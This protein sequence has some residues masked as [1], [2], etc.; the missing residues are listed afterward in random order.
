M[1]RRFH[2][3][4]LLLLAIGLLG[5][6]LTLTMRYRVE[7]ASRRVALVLDYAQL[8]TLAAATGI[9]VGEALS[10]FRSAGITGVSVS[11]EPLAGLQD[12]GVVSVQAVPVPNGQEYRLTFSNPHIASRAA[13]HLSHLVRGAT[14]IP[15]KGDRVTVAGPGGGTIYLPGRFADLADTPTGIDPDTVQQI[16]QAGLMPIARVMNP[17]GLDV[18]SLRWAL[19]GLQEQ[20]ITTVIF[21]G[22]EVLGFSGLVKETAQAFRDYGLYYGSIEFGKQ[23]GDQTMSEQLK[24]RLLRVH[25]ISSGEMARLTPKEAVERYVRASSER[26]IRLNYVRLPDTVTAHTLQD[27]LDYVQHLARDTARSGFGLPRNSAPSTFTRVWPDNLIGRL[28]VALIALGIGA[29]ALLLLASIVPVSRSLQA[30]GAVGAG[31]LCAL[32]VLSGK[33]IALQLLALLAA[34][35]FP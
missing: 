7:A 1:L 30:S 4:P 3:L 34:V 35:V 27:N 31:L 17:L 22:D 15:P 9:P 28:P 10:R 2:F 24:D 23:R 13:D 26:N 12:D 5:A 32:L 29:G 21:A 18:P 14:E 16:R 11:E 6:L 8:R 25:S 33:G 19:A 20:G